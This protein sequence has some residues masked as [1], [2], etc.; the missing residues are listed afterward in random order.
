MPF[1]Q[2]EDNQD[3]AAMLPRRFGYP[4]ADDEEDESRLPIRVRIMR[5]APSQD[6]VTGPPIAMSFAEVLE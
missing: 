2:L 5:M 6:A 4:L 3:E 1:D